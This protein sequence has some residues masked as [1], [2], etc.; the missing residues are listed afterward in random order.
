M[1]IYEEPEAVALAHQV[2]EAITGRSRLDRLMHKDD[3][4]EE[5]TEHR[6]LEMERKLLQATPLQY[7]LGRAEFLGRE[8][9]VNP[10]VLIPRPETEELVEW[11]LA[12]EKPASILDIGTGSGCISVSL[13]LGLPQAIVTA[14][15]V[16]PEALEVARG[17]A[18][19]LGAEVVFQ[20][21]NFLKE[22]E[23]E[24]LP[25]YDV[26]V[27][28]PPYIPTSEAGS[29][30]RNVRDFEPGTALFVPDGDP[31]LFYR[32]IAVFGQTHLNTG[33]SIY[34]E[35]HQNYA[36]EARHMFLESGYSTVELKIDAFG[37]ARMI[38]VSHKAQ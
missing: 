26:I 25:V 20:R 27:S 8:F 7:V 18:R 22:A 24:A 38:R 16:S 4:L 21:C 14:I 35:L 36:E 34:C 33:G 30:H 5:A 31:L 11:I 12:E 19:A 13:A 6:F 28:N 29:L 37:N 15:D 9:H 32:L 10:A 3:P 2:L 23:R 1:K 17:N